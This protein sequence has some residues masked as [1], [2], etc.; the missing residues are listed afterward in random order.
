MEDR[1]NDQL[2][3]KVGDG[4]RPCGSCWAGERVS[5]G[6]PRSVYEALPVAPGGYGDDV[7]DGIARSLHVTRCVGAGLP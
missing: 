7:L 5:A 6:W 2:G 4:L 3:L 1:T